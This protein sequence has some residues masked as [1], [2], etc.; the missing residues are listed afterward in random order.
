MDLALGTRRDEQI[1]SGFPGLP[2]ALYLQRLGVTVAS[3]PGAVSAAQGRNAR[4][5]HFPELIDRG[6][7]AVRGRLTSRNAV[8]R[9]PFDAAIEVFSPFRYH[10]PPG[11]AY[12]PRR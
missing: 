10:P 9:R 12:R 7:R 8:P 4:V 1:A 5:P 3:R 2:K 11:D 6:C